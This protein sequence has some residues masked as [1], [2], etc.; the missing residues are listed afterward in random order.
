MLRP[1]SKK[2]ILLIFLLILPWP[3]PG[4]PLQEAAMAQQDVSLD[5]GERNPGLH[6]NEPHGSPIDHSRKEWAVVLISGFCVLAAA[7]FAVGKVGQSNRRLRVEAD[8]RRTMAHVLRKSEARL[9]QALKEVRSA[10]DIKNQFLANINHEIRTPANGIIG[11]TGLL[12]GTG[13]TEE[14]QDYVNTI[15]LSTRSLLRIISDILDYSNIESGKLNLQTVE[16]ELPVLIANLVE[17][18]SAR[19][20][21]KGLQF[22]HHL[23]RAVRTQF[24]GDPQRLL[25]ILCHLLDNAVK[26]T[27]SGDVF[28]RISLQHENDSYAAVRFQVKD[29]GVGI[30][31][32]RIDRLFGS[33]TQADISHTRK[34][35]GT[36]LGLAISQHLVTK[37]DGDIGVISSPGQGSEFWFTV[38]LKKPV[39]P[40]GRKPVMAPDVNSNLIPSFQPA[41]IDTRTISATEK[42]ALR[43]LIVEDNLINQKV[44]A[45]ILDK[46]GCKSQVAGN[47][48]EAVDALRHNTYDLVLMDL[49]MPEMDGF[50]ATRT[51]RDPSGGCLNPQLPIIALT[52]DAQEETRNKCLSQGM[53]DFLTKPVNPDALMQVIRHWIENPAKSD[54]AAV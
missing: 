24:S 53:D 13:M 14:Q 18:V 33:F 34:F 36:G 20:E 26:F 49:Q 17:A 39:E 7:L 16:F 9:V 11:M 1:S 47:G 19:F 48:R 12:M 30:D 3:A 22:K 52:A 6:R 27:P 44:A 5:S 21:E 35:G 4:G 38:K 28:L 31:P 50:E 10:N 23:D 15:H 2:W 37:M 25:Q 51:I 42:R 45:K 40:A 29:T 54:P 46:C 8:K 41:S 32:E 43:I